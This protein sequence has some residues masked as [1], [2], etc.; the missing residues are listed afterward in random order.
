MR[1]RG[2]STIEFVFAM[3]ACVFLMFGMIQVFRWAGLDMAQRRW[4]HDAVIADPNKTTE[5]QLTP[6]FYR[7]SRMRVVGNAGLINGQR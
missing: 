5:Q 4:A 7:S 2:Q 1:N 6:E 3:I